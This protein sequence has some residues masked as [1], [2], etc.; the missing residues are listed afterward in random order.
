MQ[1][2]AAEDILSLTRVLKE[3][4][5]FGKLQ[6]VGTSE[7]EKRK[8]AAAL[9]VAEGLA[10]IQDQQPVKTETAAEVNGEEE[11][12]VE[13]EPVVA[14]VADAT[15]ADAGAEDGRQEGDLAEDK[16]QLAVD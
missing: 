11:D 5:L 7:A 10:R 8:K 2:K 4:W 1:V 6:T 9:K 16:M 15:E 13:E 3:T 12:R 14:P